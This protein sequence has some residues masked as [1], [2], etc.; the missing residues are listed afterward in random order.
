MTTVTH[1]KKIVPKKTTVKPKP[2]VQGS[3]TVIV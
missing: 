1:I 3:C 2:A